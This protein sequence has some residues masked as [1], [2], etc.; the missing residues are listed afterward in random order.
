[1]VLD[2]WIWQDGFLN[3]G[4]NEAVGQIDLR[5]LG[6]LEAHLD[7]VAQGHQLI[8]LRNDAILLCKR[9]EWDRC[10]AEIVLGKLIDSCGFNTLEFAPKN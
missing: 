9:R 3:R 4:F 10:R 2:D 5:G 1:M 6:G 8:N 7:A